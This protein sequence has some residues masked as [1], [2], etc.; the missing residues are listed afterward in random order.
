VLKVQAQPTEVAAQIVHL[1]QPSAGHF[2]ARAF[3]PVALVVKETAFQE[4]HFP[5]QE[6][7]LGERQPPG[8]TVA[9]DL[10]SL[11]R[12]IDAES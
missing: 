12:T 6:G 4:C 7:P 3:S 11:R 8:Q 10:G 1:D 9:L 2:V 5:R